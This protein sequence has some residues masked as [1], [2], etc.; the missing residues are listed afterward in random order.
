M[1][2]DELVAALAKHGPAAL[3]AAR[4]LLGCTSQ[5]FD[6]GLSYLD[7]LVSFRLRRA[8]LLDA[9]R[10]HQWNF[11]HVARLLGLSSQSN[12]TREMR[13]LDLMGE[14]EA[15]KAAGIPRRGGRQKR[16]ASR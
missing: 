4:E 9:L 14:Y 11:T 16:E 13:R 2:R 1:T 3:E 15:A 12:V 10:V 8:V 6:G 7:T 5:T